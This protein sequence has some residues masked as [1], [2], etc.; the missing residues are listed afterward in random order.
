[1]LTGLLS[2]LR[3]SFSRN[4]LKYLAEIPGI[5]ISDQRSYL[6]HL[7]IRILQNKLGL[8]DATLRQIF[9]EGI[10]RFLLKQHTEVAYTQLS[11]FTDLFNAK[12]LMIIVS[13][14][15]CCF[16]NDSLNISA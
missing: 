10:P 15:R 11:Y 13:D 3:R 12:I 7:Y 8:I 16:C 5:L 1:M 9:K 6:I 2:I 14:I 4:L